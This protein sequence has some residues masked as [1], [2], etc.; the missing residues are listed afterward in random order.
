MKNEEYKYFELNKGDTLEKIYFAFSPDEDT[1]LSA[2]ISF[3][4]VLCYYNKTP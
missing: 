3:F 2:E 4:S 1:F